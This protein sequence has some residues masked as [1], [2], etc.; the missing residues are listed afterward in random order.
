MSDEKFALLRPLLDQMAFHESCTG[1]SNHAVLVRQKSP[2]SQQQVSCLSAHIPAGLTPPSRLCSPPPPNTGGAICMSPIAPSV[3]SVISLAAVPPGHRTFLQ[4]SAAGRIVPT[5][6][7]PARPVGLPIAVCLRAPP[8]LFGAKSAVSP[9]SFFLLRQS[10]SP[11]PTVFHPAPRRR[12][13]SL[14]AKRAAL[15][16]RPSLIRSSSN[17]PTR[18]Q[19]SSTQLIQQ[20]V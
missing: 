3:F 17:T 19:L 6:R 10:L 12:A 16:G 8:S 20:P 11:P 5:Q 1:M 2:P 4:C 15:C 7:G 14:T 18:P 13:V 9:G